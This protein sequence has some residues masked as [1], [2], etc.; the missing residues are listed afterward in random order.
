MYF[1]VHKETETKMQKTLSVLKEDLG[2]IRAGK[3]HPSMLDKLSVD[4][5]GTVTPVKQL[6]SITS[7]EPRLL[8]IQPFDR[9]A[10]QSIEKAILISDLGLNP[11]NDGKVIRLNIP[12]LTEERRKELAKLV[13]K[14]AE[15]AKVAIRNERRDG[16]DSLKKM[17]KDGELTEDEL[18]KAQDEIQKL[19]DNYIKQIDDLVAKKEKELLEV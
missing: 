1:D 16:N 15:E 4:Y 8:L 6:A 3:A 2:S 17:Q 11:S 13:K 12:Q 5:Y 14:T 9:S 19:T 18:K 7:P 10:M